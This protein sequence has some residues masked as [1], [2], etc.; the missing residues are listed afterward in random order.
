MG[1]LMHHGERLA[2]EVL[3]LTSYD[4]YRGEGM[5]HEDAVYSAVQ[6]VTEALGDYS[7][8]NKPMIMRGSVGKLATMYKFFPL[9][10]TKLL[11]GNFFRMLPLMNKEGKKAAATKFFGVLGTHL[12]AGGLTA[13][14]MFGVV[15]SIIGA[16]WAKWGADPDAPAE[17]KDVDYLTWWKTEYMKS[18]FGSTHIADIL[19][20]GL[21]NKLTGWDI[22]SRI[23]LNDMWFR[24]LPHSKNVTEAASNMLAMLAGP[25]FSTGLDMAKGIQLGM[26]GE[27][28]LALEK[29]SPASVSKL[30][31][32][33][34]YGEEG[35]ET[36]Q[37][38][39]LLEQGKLPTSALVGQAIGFRPA[40][41]AG[42]QEKGFKAAAAE[43][44]IIENKNKIATDIKD[45]FRKSM[46]LD[47]PEIYR[48]R[49]DDKFDEAVDKLRDFNAAYPK[50][51]FEQGAI[52]TLLLEDRK[53]KANL[54][55]NAGVKL[56]PKNVRI[57]GDAV[58]SAIEDLESY[59]K[60]E[61]K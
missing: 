61:K 26:N 36:T 54:E 13:L 29:L 17:M 59:D 11:V 18:V 30:L 2:R 19:K 34:R 8:F 44:A 10:T 45:S 21:V 48:Q 39:K 33:H 15:M 31:I 1:G 50:Y 22:S 7:A 57:V 60:K 4:L 47:K 28:Q 9:V 56:T 14:P 12:L 55:M 58:D 5:K 40:K 37:G 51:K 53:L 42:A 3:F 46:D 16:A 25:A 27:Y 23:S 38:V 43:K 24:E 41:L 32:A 6:E 35:V 49:F 20:T 52:S